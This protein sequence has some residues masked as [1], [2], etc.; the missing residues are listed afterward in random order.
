MGPIPAVSE[1]AAPGASVEE[2]APVEEQKPRTD[3]QRQVQEHLVIRAGDVGLQ[4]LY[5]TTQILVLPF[6]EKEKTDKENSS[7]PAAE[8][9]NSTFFHL[10]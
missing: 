3:H 9:V 8:I 5:I 10:F 6:Q 2:P 4:V 7:K 1:P